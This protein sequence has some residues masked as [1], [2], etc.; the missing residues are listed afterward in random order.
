[1][2][3]DRFDVTAADGARGHVDALV[4]TPSAVRTMAGGNRP[5]TLHTAGWNV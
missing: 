2:N 4:V 5:V 1:M 3:A